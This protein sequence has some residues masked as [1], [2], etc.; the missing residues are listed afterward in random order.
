MFGLMEPSRILFGEEATKKTTPKKAT[1]TRKDTVTRTHSGV[2]CHMVPNP[3]V[4][5]ELLCDFEVIVLGSIFFFPFRVDNKV[6]VPWYTNH[7]ANVN[8][9]VL[10]GIFRVVGLLTYFDV[11]HPV[12]HAPS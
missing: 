2:F 7:S 10:D 8:L 12:S 1:R 6:P 9:P 3:K 5:Q 4:E 11:R